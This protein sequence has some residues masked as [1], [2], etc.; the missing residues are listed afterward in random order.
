MD[1][2]KHRRY[3]RLVILHDSYSLRKFCI[4]IM[5]S[6][7]N[8]SS[9]VIVLVWLYISLNLTLSVVIAKLF[10]KFSNLRKW[11]DAVGYGQ[12]RLYRLCLPKS[13]QNCEKWQVHRVCAGAGQTTSLIWI[14]CADTWMKCLIEDLQY[15]MI[16]VQRG[17]WNCISW[18]SDT[19]HYSLWPL[20]TCKSSVCLV[21]VARYSQRGEVTSNWSSKWKYKI[22]PTRWMCWK[23]TIA[24]T[25]WPYTIV[26]LVCIT[27]P[28]HPPWLRSICRAI[29]ARL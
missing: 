15:W 21:S 2:S 7:P 10:M 19:T 13:V 14:T 26:R 3:H 22:P 17:A 16:V 29:L 12:C 25:L 6:L 28:Y 18:K 1:F 11:I 27:L 4:Q 23:T 5:N 8:K 9:L 20:P 24:G